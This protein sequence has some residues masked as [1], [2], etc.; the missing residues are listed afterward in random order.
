MIP[1]SPSRS[2][3]DLKSHTR[4]VSAIAFT[5]DSRTLI[6]AGHD[7]TVRFQDGVWG[8]DLGSLRAHSDWIRSLAVAPDG[9]LLATCAHDGQI[10]LWELSAGDPDPGVAPH[11]EKRGSDWLSGHTGPVGQISFCPDGSLVSAGWDGTARVWDVASGCR[12]AAYRWQI[13]RLLCLAVAPDGMTA[14]GGEDGSV[15]VWDLE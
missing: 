12:R 4:P 13:G 1:F 6:T 5:P 2:P 14:A 7:G 9:R 15:V 10:A 3:H 8:K 11:A